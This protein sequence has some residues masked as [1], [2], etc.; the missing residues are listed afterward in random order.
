MAN[1]K[2]S[3]KHRYKSGLEEAI[4]EELERNKISFGYEDITIPWT[5]P[6]RNTRYK[7]DFT[8]KVNKQLWEAK[9][10]FQTAD[11]QKHLRIKEQH[12]N[13]KIKFI[14]Q[15]SKNKL[16]KHSNKTYADWCDKHGFTYHCIQTTK[17]LFPKEW[18]NAKEN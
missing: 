14:F 5:K 1:Y 18:L 15:N 8:I 3:K 16:R 13:I 9:G 17:K 11:R 10:R 12:P 6:A 7:P 4:A 2:T